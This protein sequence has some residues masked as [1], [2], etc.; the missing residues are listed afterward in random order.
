MTSRTQQPGRARSN[1]RRKVSFKVDPEL[2]A[3]WRLI[4][5]REGQR[6]PG[7]IRGAMAAL[8]GPARRCALEDCLKVLE[9]VQAGSAD[10]LA[11]SLAINAAR[12]ELGQ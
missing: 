2:H 4:A 10:A 3:A 6:L 1:R 12:K 9:R 5:Q 11:V 8:Y 7:L